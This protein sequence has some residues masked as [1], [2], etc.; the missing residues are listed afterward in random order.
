MTSVSTSRR[1]GLNSSAAIKV[2]CQVA[3]T[4]N[5][6]LAALQTIDGV[7][8]A[9]G[10]RVLVK[11]Q[12]TTSEN[13]IYVADTGNWSRDKDFD[14]AYDAL[15]GTLV[16]VI[17]GN[18]LS[19]TLWRVSTVS[20]VIGSALA[21]V[22][23]SLSPADSNSV[24]FLQA[25]AGAVARTGQSKLREFVS[26]TDFGCSPSETSVNNK[27]YIDACFAHAKATG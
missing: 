16:T 2:A 27:T 6:T 14:G 10:D 21:F 24:Q 25:G 22:Q 8:L 3:T 9:S 17:H 5:I 11:D 7:A 20:P 15:E 18:T 19:A 1:Q 23:S 26:I 4:G 13:G 12:T